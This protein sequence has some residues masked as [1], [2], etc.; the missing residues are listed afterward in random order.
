MI[1]GTGLGLFSVSFNRGT[2]NPMEICLSP[3]PYGDLGIVFG[4][5]RFGFLN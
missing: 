3:K 4:I 5:S 2:L 1:R